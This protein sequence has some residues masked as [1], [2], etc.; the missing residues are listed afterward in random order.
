MF[1]VAAA[2][3]L[4]HTAPAPVE[5]VR[6]APCE[7]LVSVFVS[8][9]W[10]S[11]QLFVPL[12]S[13]VFQVY[14]EIA[15]AVC[16]LLWQRLI[17]QEPNVPPAAATGIAAAG[18]YVKLPLNVTDP[19]AC[20]DTVAAAWQLLHTAPAPVEVVRCAPCELLTSVFVSALWHSVQLF[21][22]PPI[23]E[24]QVYV[25]IVAALCPLLW[26]RLTPQ[27]PVAG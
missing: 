27:L 21:V 4:L 10:H 24:P 22:P 12:P 3:Q 23:C 6:C 19:S 18:V 26:Q 16:P 1:T 20:V 11:V 2:W 17:P 5:V 25:V 9:L 8:A 15:W 13:A 7:L 14:S